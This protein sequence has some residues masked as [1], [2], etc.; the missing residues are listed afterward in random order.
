[1]LRNSVTP[2]MSFEFMNKASPYLNR[3][4]VSVTTSNSSSKTKP[5]VAVWVSPGVQD[6]PLLPEVFPGQV[7]TL[8]VPAHVDDDID[9]VLLW[10]QV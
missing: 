8:R 9:H 5:S 10:D 2:P 4:R 7:S 1:M 6:V 3:R